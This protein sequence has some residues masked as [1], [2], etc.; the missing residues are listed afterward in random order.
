MKWSEI[1]QSCPTLCNP[2]DCSLPG[3]SVHGVFQ[4]REL[5]WGAISF[6]RGSSWPRD[7]TW[8]YPHCRQ[9]LYHLSHQGSPIAKCNKATS[10]S[11][12]VCSV[13]QSCP[14]LCGLRDCS[15]SGSS[16]HG[17]FQARILDW[18]AISF[19]RGSFGPREQTHIFCIGRWILYHFTTW[20][21]WVSL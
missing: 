13:T 21:A 5:E 12:R 18:V 20:E 15:P 2:M 6:S 8:I 19:S 3:S 14:I 4:A 7:R 11:L 10:L 17:I 16:I 9:M 1:A